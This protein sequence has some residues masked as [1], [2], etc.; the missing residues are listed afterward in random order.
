MKKECKKCEELIATEFQPGS[1]HSHAGCPCLCHTKQDD[2][3]E[4]F[5][6]KFEDLCEYDEFRDTWKSQHLIVKS[7]I[8]DVLQAQR[9][10]FKKNVEGLKKRLIKNGLTRWRIGY[11]RAL[12]DV[13]NLLDK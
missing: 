5:E 6:S 3:E 9:E 11:N 12:F 1:M 7:F 8:Y 2:W 10:D 4:K 13:V